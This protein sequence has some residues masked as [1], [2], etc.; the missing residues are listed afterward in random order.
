MTDALASAAAGSSDDQ[1]A[2]TE[3]PDRLRLTGSRASTEHIDGAWW[4][5]SKLLADELPDLIASVGDSLG[6]VAM[7]GFRNDGWT[8]TP[9]DIAVGAGH[10]VQLL[11]FSSD[12]PS[13]VILIGENGHHLT[14]SVIAPSADEEEARRV[15]NA[16]PARPASPGGRGWAASRTIAGVATKLAEHEGRHN[17]ERD[18]EIARWCDE[19]ASQFDDV[20]IQSFVPILV[21]HIV[22]NR[23]HQSRR[24]APAAS[25]TAFS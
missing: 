22:N 14:L 21:E 15:L 4:P 17:P 1:S 13:T 2:H 24:A 3:M 9:S 23:I 11:G 16:V 20:R 18:A 6:R 10:V 5:R 7:V 25:P 8:A 12:E 19:A